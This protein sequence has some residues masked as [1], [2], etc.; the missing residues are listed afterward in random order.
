MTT[1]SQA[2]LPRVLVVDD[3]AANR[4]LLEALLAPE[5]YDVALAASGQECLDHIAGNAVDVVLLDVMMPGMDGFQVAGAIRSDPRTQ[6]L[7]IIMVTA[8]A[9]THDRIVGI[10]SGCDD[11]ISKPFD[12]N[13]VLARTRAVVRLAHLRNEQV[14][15]TREEVTAIRRE[16]ETARR[17]QEALLPTDLPRISGFDI[18]GCNRSSLEVSGDYFDVVECNDLRGRVIFA[19][20]DVSGK[21]VPAALLTANLHAGLHSQLLD[22][23]L[24][25]VDAISNLNRL[26]ALNS[27]PGFFATMILG[28]LQPGSGV[29]RYVRA[30][31]EL[32]ALIRSNGMVE[33]LQ[34]GDGLL[35]IDA[36]A[37][38]AAYEV[39]IEPGETICMYTDGVTDAESSDDDPF[40]YE[41]L[42]GVLVEHRGRSAREVGEAIVG[43]VDD[44]AH[45]Q[46]DDI[47]LLVIRR[48][49]EP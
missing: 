8:L 43:A 22:V 49:V 11:F 7:P 18:W 32:P 35:G 1:V 2:T 47:T 17:V 48:E 38:F 33:Q 6:T 29:V 23:D 19:L 12:R 3:N 25:L 41:A 10:E 31:H 30:G 5:G 21:G 16:L 36:D 20:A 14:A 24:G 13:E 46:T 34:D 42:E 39:T 9:D 28:E 40:G 45:E 37:T 26:V 4:D 15:K 44:F 27:P